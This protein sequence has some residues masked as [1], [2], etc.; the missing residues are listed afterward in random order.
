MKQQRRPP[1]KKTTQHIHH[2]PPPT[3]YSVRV[4]TN[5]RQDLQNTCCRCRCNSG[6]GWTS[7]SEGRVIIG[8]AAGSCPRI[9]KKNVAELLWGNQTIF[10]ISSWSC[11]IVNIRIWWCLKIELLNLRAV[12]RSTSISMNVLIILYQPW[13]N[14]ISPP[15]DFI[16]FTCLHVCRQIKWSMS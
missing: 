12:H 15:S 2:V 14:H 4:T 8:H 11:L 7:I 1:T 10:C 16:L 13:N 9:E 3:R 6:S 5:W